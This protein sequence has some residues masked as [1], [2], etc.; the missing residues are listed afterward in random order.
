MGNSNFSFTAKGTLMEMFNREPDKSLPQD[1]EREIGKSVRK[2]VI[3]MGL[4]LVFF[5]V[6]FG[7]CWVTR[8]PVFD[9]TGGVLGLI[10]VLGDIIFW[11]FTRKEFVTGFA[12]SMVFKDHFLLR[13]ILG[14]FGS[15]V[16]F[17][18]ILNR[19]L[20]IKRFGYNGLRIIRV[21]TWIFAGMVWVIG[22]VHLIYM[23]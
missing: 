8:S 20:T 21:L 23:L 7:D 3:I 5:T 2:A 17:E 13:P 6:Q 18:F 16:I 10:I 11:T 12:H 4:G 1:R 15:F 9:V 14:L 19:F 22:I